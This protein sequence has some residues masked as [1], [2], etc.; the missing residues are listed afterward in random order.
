MK[1]TQEEKNYKLAKACGVTQARAK[2]LGDFEPL[3][4]YFNDLNA[5][6][7]V[8]EKAIKGNDMLEDKYSI[9][10]LRAIGSECPA[11]GTRPNGS[12]ATWALASNAPS[13]ARFNALGIALNLWTHDQ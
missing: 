1:L 11:D 4:D 13:Q 8:W 10:L 12:D 9:E 3:P 2:V 6:H 7:D 5:C